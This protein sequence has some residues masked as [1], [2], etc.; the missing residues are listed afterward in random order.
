MGI[1]AAAVA[2]AGAYF[3][4]DRARLFVHF[5]VSQVCHGVSSGKI[6]FALGYVAAFAVAAALGRAPSPPSRRGMRGFHAV[7]AMGLLLAMATHLIYCMGLHL[8]AGWHSY[9]WR[10]GV[11]SINCSTHIHTSKAV[12]ALMVN[13]LHLPASLH[14]RFD[15]GL[16]YLDAVPTPLLLGVGVCFLG[17]LGLSLVTGPRCVGGYPRR[18]QPFVAL[19]WALA[20]A[21]LCKGILDGGPL[22]YDV[23]VAWLTLAVLGSAGSLEQAARTLKARW[24]LVCLSVLLWLAAVGV[25]ELEFAFYQA[26]E[27]LYRLCLYA[28]VLSAPL[29]PAR[30]WAAGTFVLSTAVAS[31]L[32]WQSATRYLL[33]LLARAPATAVVYTPAP[34]G[35]RARQADVSGAGDYVG[36]YAQLGET[37]N[38]VRW[39]SAPRQRSGTPTGLY[40]DLKILRWTGRPLTSGGLVTIR[41]A[42][43]LEDASHPTFRLE[44]EFD[45]ATGP[46]LW[47]GRDV[48]GDQ[49]DENERHVAYRLL[50]ARLR[51][52]GVSQYVLI[53]LAQFRRTAPAAD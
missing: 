38:R 32:A 33:P 42:E 47:R 19:V 14:D 28:L 16:A 43:P 27:F 11:G 24:L 37:A 46:V 15:T 10:D 41:R 35:S 13:W 1:A 53:P 20:G 30:R 18:Q 26:R 5:A 22:G 34:E 9:H 4:G 12:I 6:L 21:S 52:C 48:P 2:A 8:S 7:V 50:D 25:I 40:A 31:V 39:V 44:V 29:L 3:V 49:L 45:A 36:L 23:V 17:A 51:A